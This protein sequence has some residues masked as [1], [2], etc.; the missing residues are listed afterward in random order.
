[1]KI[2]DKRKVGDMLAREG[3]AQ[4]IIEIAGD[5]ASGSYKNAMERAGQISVLVEAASFDDYWGGKVNIGKNREV[6]VFHGI[7]DESLT[8]N[9]V[10]T[11]VNPYKN[12][13]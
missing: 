11:R 8:I 7:I 6:E 4:R 5:I 12:N 13:C 1:M 3:M 10:S 9:Q 2:A